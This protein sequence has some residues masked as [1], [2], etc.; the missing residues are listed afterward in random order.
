MS[1]AQVVAENGHQVV[2]LPSEIRLEGSEVT[3][4]KIGQAVLLLPR[5]ADRWAMLTNSLEQFTDDF[6]DCRAQ[7]ANQDRDMQIE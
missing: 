7:P 1:T 6:M 5:N 2:H 4:K 3:V